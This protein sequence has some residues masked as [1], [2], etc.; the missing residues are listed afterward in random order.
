MKDLIAR[1]DHFLI[2]LWGVVWDSTRVFE[3]GAA[4]CRWLFDEGKTVHFLSNTAEFPPEHLAGRLNDAGLANVTVDNLI[5]SGQA[6]VSWFRDND[7]IGKEVYMFG[8]EGN[9]ENVRRAGC[10]PIDLPDDPQTIRDNPRSS[11]VV[12]GGLLNFTWEEFER[13]VTAVSLGNLT[14]LVPNPDRIVVEQSGDIVMPAGMKAHVIE[15][16]VPG[17][18]MVRLGKPFTFIYEYA[19][20]RIGVGDDRSRVLMVGDS[21]ETDIRGANNAGIDSLLLGQS[22]HMGQSLDTIRAHAEE[23]GAKP[24]WFTPKLAPDGDVVRCDW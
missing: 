13:C 17:A 21:L 3:G 12:V 19:F 7:L 15:A 11:C 18:K 16:A 5:I 1:Y 23:V 6:M 8:G 24:T 9:W 4:F 10:E 20:E 2:D 14:V 22:V